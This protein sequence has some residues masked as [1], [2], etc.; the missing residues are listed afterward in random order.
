[1]KQ[2]LSSELLI[3]NLNQADVNDKGRV[4][5]YALNQK[6]AKNNLLKGAKR[7]NSLEVESKQG[8]VTLSFC[9]GSFFE[10]ILPLIRDW[11]QKRGATFRINEI[12]VEIIEVV[13]GTEN[14]EKHVDTKLIIMANCDRIVIHVYNG[15]QKVMVQGKN[16]EKFVF[17]Y[18]EPFFRKQIQIS[19]EKIIR[20]VCDL[21]WR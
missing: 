9:D 17:D 12:E 3:T 2:V 4:F 21:S 5:D 16:Y 7:I 13:K 11:Q 1:M 10:I 19:K 6:R 14:S 8:C 20:T 15:R 18:L